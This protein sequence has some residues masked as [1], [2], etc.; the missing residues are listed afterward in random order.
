LSRLTWLAAA[1][2]IAAALGIGVPQAAGVSGNDPI[3]MFAGTGDDGIPKDGDQATADGLDPRG[4]VAAPNGDVYLVDDANS[5]IDVVSGGIIKG[6]GFGGTNMEGLALDDQGNLYVSQGPLGQGVPPGQPNPN[7]DIG[8]KVYKV[9]GG[10]GQV[11]AGTGPGT[12]NGDGIQATSANLAYPYGLAVDSRGDVY[13]S[14]QQGNRIRKVSNGIIT[15]VAGTGKAGF[16]GDG[17]P[18]TSAQIN[19]PSDIAFDRAGNLYIADTG[20]NRVRKLSPD[21]I[22]TTVAGTGTGTAGYSG[23]GQGTSTELNQPRGLAVDGAGNVYIGDT[24]N[25]RLRKLAGG[26]LTTIAGT[27]VPGGPVQGEPA[28]NAPLAY[29]SPHLAVDPQ[30]NLYVPQYYLLWKISNQVPAATIKASPAGGRAPLTVSFDGSGS[31][32]PDGKVTS[33]SWAFGDGAKE[34]GSTAKHTYGK[35]GTYTATLTVTDDS[36][37][38]GAM[39]RKV[40]VSAATAT[41]TATGLSVGKARAGRSFTVSFTVRSGGQAVKGSLSCSA[42]VNGKPLSASHHSVS[43]SGLASCAWNLPGSSTGGRLAGSITESYKGAT[44][45]RSFSVKVA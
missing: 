27:G 38:T 35:A 42:S 22:I 23:D 45:S 25:H 17:G 1:V 10:T 29:P 11:I 39:T 32:D 37:A 44:V 36:G 41:L 18:G 40:T 30:G 7:P 24:L 19:E 8:N 14:E 5:G 26:I 9:S 43:S 15:T 28:S 3:T 13:I 31:S 4:V 34:T 20:N 6:V 16:S 21:G 33:Y 12:F 2:G